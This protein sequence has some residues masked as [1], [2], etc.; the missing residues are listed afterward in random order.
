[1]TE[2]EKS[3]DLPG[4]ATIAPPPGGLERLRHTI[5]RAPS[6]EPSVWMLALGGA[7]SAAIMLATVSFL[8]DMRQQSVS[9]QRIVAQARAYEKT[10][11]TFVPVAGD[12]TAP[13]RVYVAL[14]MDVVKQDVR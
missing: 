8:F 10:T 12:E 7:I 14:P 11:H 1:M 9:V 3:S 5:R 2:N 13:I 6:P 4:W